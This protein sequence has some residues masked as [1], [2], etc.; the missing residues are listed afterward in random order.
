MHTWTIFRIVAGIGTVFYLTPFALI[1][2]MRQF[3]RGYDVIETCL[4]L[5][6]ATVAIMCWWFVLRGNVVESRARM[7]AALKG[8][9][10]FLGIGFFAGFFGAIILFPKS[11]QGPLLGIF[12][13]GP[14]GFCLGTI[15]GWLYTMIRGIPHKR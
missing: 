8:G 13:T 14:I 11:N 9:L 3:Q 10:V 5:V 7:V 4:G 15:L 12:V 2:L 1:T 6:G